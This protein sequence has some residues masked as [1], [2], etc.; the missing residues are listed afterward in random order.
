MVV[1]FGKWRML[2]MEKW[3]EFKRVEEVKVF[4]FQPQQHLGMQGLRSLC[5]WTNIINIM[6]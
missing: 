4:P 6:I 5:V 2:G 1:R 3:D